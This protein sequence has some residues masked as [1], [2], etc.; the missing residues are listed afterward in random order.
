MLVV[1]FNYPNL[2]VKKDHILYKNADKNSQHWLSLIK[3]LINLADK[4]DEKNTKN[5]TPI[6]NAS[7][8]ADELQKLSDLKNKGIITE[9]EFFDVIFCCVIIFNKK[10]VPVY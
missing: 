3:V 1:W 10:I 5:E 7:S 9:A 2:E 4:E 8:V 6:V